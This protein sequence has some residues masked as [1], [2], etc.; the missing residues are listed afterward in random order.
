MIVSSTELLKKLCLTYILI[1][2]WI[3]NP[4]TDLFQ[5]LSLKNTSLNHANR[6]T[7]ILSYLMVTHTVTGTFQ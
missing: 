5:P 2:F 4:N 1:Y 6:P 7:F 3:I